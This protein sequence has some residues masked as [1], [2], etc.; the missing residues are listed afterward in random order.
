MQAHQADYQRETVN[1]IRFFYAYLFFLRRKL[2]TEMRKCDF[3]FFLLSFSL[4]A[5]RTRANNQFKH[6]RKTLKSVIHYSQA[7]VVLSAHGSSWDVLADS[8]GKRMRQDRRETRRRRR[9]DVSRSA[10]SGGRAE[11]TLTD[12]VQY[13]AARNRNSF[14][15]LFSPAPDG[16]WEQ[17]AR[18]QLRRQA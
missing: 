5:Q 6:P 1:L 8:P 14:P 16:K 2:R 11:S 7:V 10:E 17:Q 9:T 12:E 18:S 4:T 15:V 13:V 3:F